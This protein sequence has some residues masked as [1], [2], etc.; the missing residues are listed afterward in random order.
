MKLAEIADAALWI[1]KE[2][3]EAGAD[4]AT[5]EEVML[6]FLDAKGFPAAGVLVLPKSVLI[7]LNSVDG[8]HTKMKHIDDVSPNFER[9][10]L[11][12]EYANK[13]E[14]IDFNAFKQSVLDRKPPFYILSFVAVPIGC[15]AFG[16]LLGCDIYGALAVFLASYLAFFIKYR[17]VKMG[18]SMVFVNLIC[19]YFATLFAFIF[20]KTLGV[21]SFALAQAASTFFLIPGIQLINTFEDMLRGHYLNGSARGLRALFLS[22]GI[23]LGTTLAII[24]ERS[25]AWLF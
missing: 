8:F 13:P 4:S 22:F 15:A 7:T 2:M 11:I 23:V 3:M 21:D 5:V 14:E 20:S 24:T 25:I 16:M 19:A 9:M 17:V 1:G 10:S 12:Y 18:L 6:S